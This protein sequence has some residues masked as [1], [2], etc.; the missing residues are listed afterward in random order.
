MKAFRTN[1]T[2]NFCILNEWL[3]NVRT[4]KPKQHKDSTQE[5]TEAIIT[6]NLNCVLFYTRPESLCGTHKRM[7][8]TYV[9]VHL[10]R[11][12][13]TFSDHTLCEC[14]LSVVCKCLCVVVCA[15]AYFKCSTIL[16]F[17]LWNSNKRI[18]H[19]W[20]RLNDNSISSTHNHTIT[21]APN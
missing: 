6:F 8:H 7:G 19:R 5:P 20:Y 17:L 3:K 18:G 14:I 4:S 16:F 11:M 15:S 9:I 2:N 13:H 10:K 12:R 1:E 21:V